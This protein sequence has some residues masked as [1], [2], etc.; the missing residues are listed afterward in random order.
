MPLFVYV[1]V[2]DWLFLLFLV[3]VSCLYVC[4]S[5]VC[6]AVLMFVLFVCVFCCVLLV[7][8]CLFDSVRFVHLLCL[9]VLSVC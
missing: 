8:S 7:C 4:V 9:S 5:D 1:C 2:F 3:C 6:C